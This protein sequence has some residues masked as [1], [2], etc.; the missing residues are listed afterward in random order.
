MRYLF[1][2]FVLTSTFCEAQEVPKVHYHVFKLL[3]EK[4]SEEGIKTHMFPASLS[5]DTRK[6]I[7]KAKTQQYANE[8]DRVRSLYFRLVP[9]ERIVI[10]Q[11]EYKNSSGIYRRIF[12]K[13][14][15]PKSEDYKINAQAVVDK[16]MA[17]SM[18]KSYYQNSYKVLYD[19]TPFSV[20]KNTASSFFDT[21]YNSLKKELSKEL[22]ED[23]KKELKE[24]VE[25]EKKKAIAIGKRG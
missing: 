17:S 1:L 21:M 22:S 18:E 14:F 24:S 6:R 3:N 16:I 11:L 23:E 13:D 4:G 25:K 10:V 7:K 9:N 5:D 20:D 12:V 19:G 15:D 8:A 2:L